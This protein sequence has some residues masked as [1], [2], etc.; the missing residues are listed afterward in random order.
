MIGGSMGAM[1]FL[2]IGHWEIALASGLTGLFLTVSSLLAV[3]LFLRFWK[4][5]PSHE[6]GRLL[7]K[8]KRPPQLTR[9]HKGTNVG[10]LR[11]F[12]DLPTPSGREPG[13]ARSVLESCTDTE[14][15]RYDR[16]APERD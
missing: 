15:K 9:P 5:F 14:P 6:N 3:L 7:P 1:I 2:S 4:N 8:K 10:L 12:S 13:A 11:E 16:R